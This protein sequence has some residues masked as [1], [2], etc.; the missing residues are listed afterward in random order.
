MLLILMHDWQVINL[1]IN[2]LSEYLFIYLNVIADKKK[3][4]YLWLSF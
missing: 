1:Y 3:K 4:A 2:K